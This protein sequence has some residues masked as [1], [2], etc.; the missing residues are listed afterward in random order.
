[1]TLEDFIAQQP[2]ARDIASWMK[3]RPDICGQ[4]KK[5]LSSREPIPAYLIHKWL[6]KEFKFPF[7]DS[8]FRRWATAVRDGW[9]AAA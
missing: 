9:D 5:A 7:S 2:T 4:V 3:V 8:S 6:V 1:M